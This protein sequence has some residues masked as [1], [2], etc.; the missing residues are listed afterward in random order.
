MPLNWLTLES[1]PQNVHVSVILRRTML[2]AS[3]EMKR[4]SPS[5]MLNILLVS[6]GITI[7]PRSSILRVIPES[8]PGAEPTREGMGVQTT[9]EGPA[10]RPLASPATMRWVDTHCHLQLDG[11][12]PVTLLARA[13]NVEWLVVPGVDLPSSQAAVELAR[14]NPERIV[15]SA[16]LHPH[17]AALWPFQREALAELARD[18]AAIGETGLDFYR[19]LSPRDAQ[20]TAFRDQ[21]ELSAELGK[22]VIVHCRDAFAE[23][24]QVLADTD[25]GA[26]AV[27]HSWT[28]GRRWTRR[29]LELGVMF[30]FSGTV[31]FETGETIRLGAALVPPESALVETDT[32]Y[33]APPPHR[34]QRNE[35]AWVE[36]VGRALADV[37]GI[38]PAEVARITAEN[39]ARVFL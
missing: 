36:H 9:I 29:F 7:R 4:W 22:P 18:V 27:L 35:P 34:G 12:D 30:S 14:A 20:L 19:D 16:G 11:R 39:A 37:W 13:G 25:A 32:P 2:P 15:P 33:L 23:V 17:D 26:R 1:D 31:A 28:G 5:L 6:A 21:I 24:H 3:T 8:M 10:S 38:D